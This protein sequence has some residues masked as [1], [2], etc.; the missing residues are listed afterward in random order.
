MTEHSSVS[1]RAARNIAM[2]M[3]AGTAGS[4]NLRAFDSALPQ[5]A[6]SLGVTLGQTGHFTAA[7]ALAY[8]LSQLPFGLLGDRMDKL[9]LVR[10]LAAL[11]ALVMLATALAAS[12]PAMLGLR[13]VAGAASSAVIP[14]TISYIGD[15]VPFA[16][17]QIVLAWNMTT[18]TAGVI[19]GQAAGGMIA[20]FI[21]W[22]AIPVFVALLYLPA[23]L[24]LCGES[25]G[26]GAPARRAMRP[27]EALRAVFAR[28]FSRAILSG[29][30]LEGAFIFSA[31]AFCGMSL[32]VRFDLSVG[33]VGL[34]LTIYALGSIS[35]VALLRRWP[36]HWGMR[37]HFTLGGALA[38]L[39]LLSFALAPGLPLALVGLFLAGL[40]AAAVHNNFQ[41]FASQLLPESR[42]TG[43]ACFAT[44]F[45]LSQSLGGALLSMLVDHQGV[46]RVFLWCL[47]PIA[48]LTLWFRTRIAAPTARLA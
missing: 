23:V 33:A 38:A 34:L 2:L 39:G 43:F 19:L 37:G 36:E 5:L 11:S 41:T 47:L 8:G 14:L 3:A 45:F 20:G 28:P 30:F 27:A 44:T 16:R 24:G 10:L 26:A 17:R 40:G 29:A 31:S 22:H 15:T 42:A 46:A 1:P 7:Y 21:D 35:N 48:F 12:Y 13:L 9:K 32:A 4:A 6:E 25:T 18:L